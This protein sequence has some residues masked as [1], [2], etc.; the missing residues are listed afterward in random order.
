M[1]VMGHTHVIVIGSSEPVNAALHVLSAVRRERRAR[2][3]GA[4]TRRGARP[5]CSSGAACARRRRGGRRAARRARRTRRASRAR[6]PSSRTGTW[7]STWTRTPRAG[8]GACSS[9][10][11]RGSAPDAAT[12]TRLHSNAHAHCYHF[13]ILRSHF[14]NCIEY[15]FFRRE[16]NDRQFTE[17]LL[18]ERTRNKFSCDCCELK[19]VFSLVRLIEMKMSIVCACVC[20]RCKV[21]VQ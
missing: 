15:Q 9:P 14:H 13:S 8:T 6:S 7:A 12:C 5:R 1:L 16:A 3:W 21:N 4:R 18:I 17:H 2:K 19:L 10:A 11:P 20:I